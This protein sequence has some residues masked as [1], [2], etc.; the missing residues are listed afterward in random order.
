MDLTEI[1]ETVVKIGP[2]L[3][4]IG[5]PGLL[6]GWLTLEIRERR[7]LQAVLE[8]MAE[9]TTKAL[10]DAN[11]GMGKTRDTMNVISMMLNGIRDLMLVGGGRLPTFVSPPHEIDDDDDRGTGG[12]A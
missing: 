10:T 12:V 3:T 4:Q 9:R 7:R 1:I 11:H 5:I 8:A 2:L 6:L